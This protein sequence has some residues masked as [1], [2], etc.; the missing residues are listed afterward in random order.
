VYI[1]P[2]N[3]AE[4]PGTGA[5]VSWWVVDDAVGTDLERALDDA[6]PA[7]LADHWPLQNIRFGV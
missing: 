6:V 5:I 7:W 2:P 3:D 1:D 4:A